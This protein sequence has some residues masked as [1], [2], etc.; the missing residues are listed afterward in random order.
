MWRQTPSLPRLRV[1]V[2]GAISARTQMRS[3]IAALVCTFAA[4]LAHAEAAQVPQ[5]NLVSDDVV[6]SLSMEANDLSCSAG[7]RAQ[8][9]T[10]PDEVSLCPEVAALREE[11]DA[12]SA[13][14]LAMK[15][16]IFKPSPPPPPPTS[17]PLPPPPFSQTHFVT[18]RLTRFEP[19]FNEWGHDL[20]GSESCR[21]R[22]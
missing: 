22:Q 14:L 17:P 20:P 18:E 1:E 13:D 10:C 5:L 21:H 4:L 15:Q 2:V 3:P 6:V 9:F 8:D 16:Y 11:L 12:L 7:V 19:Y